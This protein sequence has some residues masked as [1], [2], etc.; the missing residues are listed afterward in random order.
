MS[1]T[2]ALNG[3]LS[4]SHA[5]SAQLGGLEEGVEHEQPRAR[6]VRVAFDELGLE[7]TR[8]CSCALTSWASQGLSFGTMAE[9]V[10]VIDAA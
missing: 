7:R 8:T 10:S 3:A 2:A 5:R 6:V 1:M 9:H 4:R